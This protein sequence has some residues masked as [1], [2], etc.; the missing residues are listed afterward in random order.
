MNTKQQNDDALLL[1]L[2]C[3]ATLEAAAAKSGLSRRTIYRRLDDPGFRQRLQNIRSE[4]VER[5]GAM[6]TAAAMEAVR[7]LLALMERTIPHATRLGAARSVLELGVKLRDLIEV[8]QR[9]AVLEEQVL[10]DQPKGKSS[11]RLCR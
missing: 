2:A 1:A 11:S 8:E 4:M 9:L 5:A 6:L 3:G 7:T 10:A